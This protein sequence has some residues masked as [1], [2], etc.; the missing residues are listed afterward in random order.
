MIAVV[1]MHPLPFLFKRDCRAVCEPEH[2][3]LPSVAGGAHMALRNDLEY[4]GSHTIADQRL[5]QDIIRNL[6]TYPEVTDITALR[7]IIRGRTVG[8]IMM[9]FYCEPPESD[10]SGAGDDIDIDES[11]DSGWSRS[12]YSPDSVSTETVLPSHHTVVD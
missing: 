5:I 3:V 2:P 6:T 9:Y 10:T 7:R 8:R 1:S 4:V 12:D 11:D